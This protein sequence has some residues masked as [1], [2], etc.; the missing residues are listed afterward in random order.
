LAAVERKAAAAAI[1]SNIG[2]RIF[3]ASDLGLEFL[4]DG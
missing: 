3:M 1:D 2:R 4:N